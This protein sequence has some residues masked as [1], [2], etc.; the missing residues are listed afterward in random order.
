MITCPYFS[1]IM[2]EEIKAFVSFDSQFFVPLPSGKIEISN[3]TM[4]K[5]MRL[6]AL[7]A[8]GILVCGAC[9]KKGNE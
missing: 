1:P 9:G 3:K 4:K 8:I 7:L 6:L 2:A 5:T